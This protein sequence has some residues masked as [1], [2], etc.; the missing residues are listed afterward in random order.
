MPAGAEVLA[1]SAQIQCE[2][3]GFA[4]VKVDGTSAFNRQRRQQAFAAIHD[5]RPGLLRCA[6]QRYN[7]LSLNLTWDEN[8]EPTFIEATEGWGQGDPFAPVG[9]SYGIRTPI[10]QAKGTIAHTVTE[11]TGDT[12]QGSTMRI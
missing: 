9:F 4:V 6:T 10:R 11:L 2:R 3:A 5:C 8:G 12:A 7:G 1:E